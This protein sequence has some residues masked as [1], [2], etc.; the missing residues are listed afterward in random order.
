MTPEL[1]KQLSEHCEARHL[2]LSVIQC[3][4]LLQYLALLCQW[5]QHF[6]LTGLRDARRMLEVLIAESLD[7]CQREVLPPTAR[8]L[9]LGTGAGVP[10]IPLAISSPDLRLT[11]LDRT[12][13]KITFLR[14][15]VATLHLENCQPYCSA[16]EA[17]RYRLLPEQR[18]D[19]IVSR[20][21]GGI[22][23]VFRLAAP[24][25]LP[26]GKLILRKPLRPHDVQEAEAFERAMP[27]VTTHCVAL[28]WSGVPAWYLLVITVRP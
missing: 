5:R 11:L 2:Q 1:R 21:V 9:D 10:G 28:P 3:E 6:N 13:K 20:G 24:L 25:L 27:D 26:G 15:V 23:E 8:V 22:D 12:Q 7:F 4:Q 19:V 16:A 17:F 14:R 18:F